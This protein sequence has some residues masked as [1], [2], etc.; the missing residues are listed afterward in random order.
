MALVKDYIA[1]ALFLHTILSM[2]INMEF[3][4]SF[5]I[6]ICFLAI[7]IGVLGNYVAIFREQ[8]KL[9]DEIRKIETS[10]RNESKLR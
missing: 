6:F 2:F 1:T 10:D 7:I 4:F 5:G 3:T 8:K 9:I